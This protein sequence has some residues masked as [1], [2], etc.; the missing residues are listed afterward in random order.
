MKPFK[1]HFKAFCLNDATSSYLL[2]FHL[3]QGKDEKRP[4]MFKATEWPIVKLLQPVK[5]HN[6]SHILATDNCYASI[7]LAIFC[8]CIGTIFLT[9]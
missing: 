3:Y 9:P 6:K 4:E 2:N 7:R 1:W 8:L 5:F